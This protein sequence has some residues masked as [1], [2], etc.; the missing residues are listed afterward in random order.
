[1]LR[2]LYSG[3]FHTD[4]VA[5]VDDFSAVVT[6]MGKTTVGHSLNQWFSNFNVVINTGMDMKLAVFNLF[7]PP[8]YAVAH[9]ARLCFR[10]DLTSDGQLRHYDHPSEDVR[11]HFFS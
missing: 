3:Y 4:Y 9:P 7:T 11:P 1:M 2:V 5:G 6:S 10:A 8:Q